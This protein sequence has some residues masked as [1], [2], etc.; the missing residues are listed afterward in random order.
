MFLLFCRV[1]CRVEVDANNL[2]WG[3]LRCL[4]LLELSGSRGTGRREGNGTRRKTAKSS[5]KKLQE[6]VSVEYCRMW[7]WPQC[8][9]LPNP[10]RVGPLPQPGPPPPGASQKEP[11]GVGGRGRG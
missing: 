7:I 10:L 6:T 1:S 3:G 5:K 9:P 4:E 11:G 8:R 2:I